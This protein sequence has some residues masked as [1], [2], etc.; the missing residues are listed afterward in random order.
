MILLSIF[1][2]II[3]NKVIYIF[4]YLRKSKHYFNYLSCT[5]SQKKKMKKKTHIIVKSI[6]S[7]FYSESTTQLFSNCVRRAVADRG[8]NF[9][10]RGA[11][12]QNAVIICGSYFLTHSYNT[13]EI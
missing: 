13:W 1:D 12:I 4:N 10:R 5:Q 3:V 7:L 6:H 11:I 8:F 9:L 2:D